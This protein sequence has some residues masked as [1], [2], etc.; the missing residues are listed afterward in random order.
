MS[1]RILSRCDSLPNNESARAALACQAL[2]LVPREHRCPHCHTIFRVYYKM[3]CA[4]CWGPRYDD[5]CHECHFQT[6]LSNF[7]RIPDYPRQLLLRELHPLSHK[8][9]D[10]WI[11]EFQHTWSSCFESQLHYGLDGPLFRDLQKHAAHRSSSVTTCPRMPSTA[12]SAI[13]RPSSSSAT[14]KK[15]SLKKSISKRK[16]Q[17]QGR[18]FIADT[19]RAFSPNMDALNGIMSGFGVLF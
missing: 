12:S 13:K 10:P 6:I 4:K 18:T 5:S 8:S 7:C 16:V 2:R 1:S 9:M 3:R 19:S 15:L 11:S 17:G 14:Y